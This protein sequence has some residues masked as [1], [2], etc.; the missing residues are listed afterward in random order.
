[1]NE[2][3]GF[4]CHFC[5]TCDGHGCIGELPGMGGVFEN[6]NFIDNCEAWS[7]YYPAV[8]DR[9]TASGGEWPL[10]VP[11]RLAPITGAIQNVGY[12]DEKA[13][14]DDIIAASLKAGLRLSIGDGYP[15]EK[16]KFGITAMT[17]SGAKGAVFIKPYEN[18]K[19][20]ERMEWAASVAEFVG[21]DIDSWAILTMRNLVN[22][23]NKT[24]SQLLELKRAAKVPFMIKGIFRPEDIELVREV[25][26]DVAVISNHGGRVETLRG[27]TAAFLSAHGK[28]LR[29]FAGAVWVDGGIRT[30]ADIRAAA[31]LGVDEVM[32][33]RPFI[34]AL[35]KGGREGV[36]DRMRALTGVT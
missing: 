15:D 36:R 19:I 18:R 8:S 14:Y 21:V 33:G 25:R 7:G 22:L 28:E 2:T 9:N 1:M 6:A 35:C 3:T 26:P 17:A 29:R 5:D 23:E 20:L 4:R 32:M 24:A 30:G 31:A 34:T 10:P 13:F 12:P 16:L 11:V 27:S